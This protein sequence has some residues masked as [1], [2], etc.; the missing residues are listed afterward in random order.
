[1][2]TL[3]LD[4]PRL[5][6][7]KNHLQSTL[8]IN[9]LFAQQLDF[10]ALSSTENLWLRAIAKLFENPQQEKQHYGKI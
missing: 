5:V 4:L 3:A 8:S 1:L 10:Q 2:Q 6:M 9:H 7:L